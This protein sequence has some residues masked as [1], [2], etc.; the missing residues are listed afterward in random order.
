MIFLFLKEFQYFLRSMRLPRR[1][2]I[3]M[4]WDTFNKNIC[5]D[6]NG[7]EIRKLA[8]KG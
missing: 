7:N 6:A 1:F 3:V 8:E 4:T 2:G 5:T